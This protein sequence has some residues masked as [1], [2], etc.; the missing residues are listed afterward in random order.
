MESAL[1]TCCKGIKIGKI[2]VVRHHGANASNTITPDCVS[3]M[4]PASVGNTAAPAA[5]AAAVANGYNSSSSAADQQQQQQQGAGAELPRLACNDRSSSLGAESSSGGGYGNGSSK[6][7]SSNAGDGSSSSRGS[8][9][10]LSRTPGAGGPHALRSHSTPLSLQRSTDFGAAAAAAAA[11]SAFGSISHQ[12]AQDVIYE[13]LPADIA[14]RHVLL[15]DPVLSTGNSAC[16]A[17]EVNSGCSSS[18]SSSI[19]LLIL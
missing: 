12:P 3:P 18:S 11:A 5:A 7:S 9:S 15:M 8:R 6:S 14:E 4:P 19:V 17:I 13:R 2:L 10:P 1:R 16:R